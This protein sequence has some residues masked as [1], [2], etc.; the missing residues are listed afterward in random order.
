MSVAIPSRTLFTELYPVKSSNIPTLHAWQATIGTNEKRSIGWKMAYRMR[1]YLG[2]HCIWA[3]NRLISDLPFSAEEI[4]K[5]LEDLWQVQNVDFG[6]V[7]ELK[8]DKNWHPKPITIAEF[9]AMG[10]VSDLNQSIRNILKKYRRKIRNGYIERD[11]YVRGWE[12]EEKPVISISVS[13]TIY[14]NYI[15][16]NLARTVDDPDKFLGLFVRDVTS[17]Y[18]GEIVEIVGRLADHRSRLEKWT[19]RDLMRK[20]IQNAPEDDLVMKIKASY[21]D[22]YDYISSVLQFVVRTK[23]YSRLNING[24]EALRSLQIKPQLRADIVQ[25]IATQIASSDYIRSQ[26]LSSA[27]FATSF[28]TGIDLNFVPQAKL[29]DGHTCQADAR[30]MLQALK[31]HPMYRRESSLKGKPMKIGVFNMVGDHPQGKSYL[32]EIRNELVAINFNVEFTSVERVSTQSQ[33]EME[34]AI[35]TLQKQEPSIIMGFI[36]NANDDDDD[37]NLYNQLKAYFIKN[38]IQSQFIYESTIGNQY[39]LPN[40]ILGII[41]KTGNVPYVLEEKLPYADIVAGIDVARVATVRRSGSRSIPALTRIYT[42]EGDFLRYILSE[43]P[44]EGETL[45]RDLLRQMFPS[46]YFAGK[47]VVIHRDG[48]WR[49]DEQEELYKWAEELNSKFYLVEVIKSGVPRIYQDGNTIDRPQKGDCVILN[50]RE[51]ILVSS[52]PPHKNYT[53]RPLLIRTDENLSIEEALHSI[54]S[55]TL[56]HYGAV[57]QPRLPVTIHYSDRIGYLALRGI[58]PSSSEGSKP[59]W[60]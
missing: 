16:A 47:K 37:D 27:H 19:T 32:A 9:V 14:S 29:G 7:R 41:G 6:Q 1:K 23:D 26:P 56:L 22:G 5:V 54:L 21:S 2:G 53:P 42:A 46:K 48:P 31:N 34:K 18:K 50:Q 8:A 51:A 39:A 17:D 45:D 58:K 3:E 36:P 15:L 12:F 24:Q 33:V 60:L 44:I 30:T 38:D 4:Q 10:L 55:L 11:Y 28:K 20:R 25:E 43:R 59:Y 52:L 40:I 35:D 13:S 57:R 49:G